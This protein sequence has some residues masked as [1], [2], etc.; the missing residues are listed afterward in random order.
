MQ[1]P[2]TSATATRSRSSTTASWSY[3]VYA[4]LPRGSRNSRWPAAWWCPTRRS[5]SG[6]PS[7]DRNTPAGC[8]TNGNGPLSSGIST[9]VLDDQ[10]PSAVSVA[11]RRPGRH[12]VRHPDP[13]ASKRE[14]RHEVL[15]QAPQ[16][17]VRVSSG[18]GHRQAPQLRSGA[19]GGDAVGR[20][21]AIQIPEPGGELAPAHPA[22]RTRD[23][24]RFRTPGSQWL[25]AAFARTSPH[26][27]P[28]LPSPP[29]D[30]YRTEMT[31]RFAVWNEVT[32]LTAAV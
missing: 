9:R 15:P 22:T 13:V 11:G 18:A 29:A 31:R 28:L 26:F 23:S 10:R 4:E 6:A 7:S 1:P 12:R 30:D 5:G 19:S 21:R 25:P 3:L 16:E 20:A 2:P 8:A 32:G 27:R 14:G 17:A 24:E